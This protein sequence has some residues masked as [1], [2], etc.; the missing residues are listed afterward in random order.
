[1]LLRSLDGCKLEQ[2]EGSRHRGRSRRKVLIVQMDDAWIV[3]RLDGISRRPNGCKGSDFSNLK[4]VQNL[5][6]TFL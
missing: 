2:F 4:F 1:M 6:E 3:E 5:L